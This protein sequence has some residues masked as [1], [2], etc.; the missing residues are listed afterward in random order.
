MWLHALPQILGGG[1]LLLMSHREMGVFFGGGSRGGGGGG[2]CLLVCATVEGGQ[3]HRS[4]R[5]CRRAGVRRDSC[6]A[7]IL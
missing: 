5:Q 3:Y 1:K 7:L 2:A 6:M 4:C